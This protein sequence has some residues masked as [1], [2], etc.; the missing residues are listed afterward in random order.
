[1]QEFQDLVNAEMDRT[2]LDEVTAAKIVSGRLGEAAAPPDREIPR[3][4]TATEIARVMA[5]PPT[6]NEPTVIPAPPPDCLYCN[7]GGWYKEAVEMGHPHFGKLFPCV[8][9]LQ[10]RERQLSERRQKYLG[11]LDRELG[12]DL[13]HATLENFDLRRARKK[14]PESGQSLRKAL[15]AAISCL[16]THSWLY[17]W[18]Q[19]GVGKSHLAAA[20]ARSA[21]AA[22]RSAAYTSAPALLRFLRAGFQDRSS[23]ERLLALQTVDL[24]ALDDLGAEHH[25]RDGDWSDSVLFELINARYGADAQTIIT[26]NVSIDELEPRIRSRIGG[27]AGREGIVLVDND[28][29]RRR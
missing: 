24:L 9:T 6:M 15:Q 20:V 13:R 3:T 11:Q 28:D 22:G 27:K 29:Q 21:A 17:L 8:C 26:S 12:D 16:D 10:K 2:G 5:A 4:T 25:T 14:D 1:M 7:G 18:G 19:T 23:D